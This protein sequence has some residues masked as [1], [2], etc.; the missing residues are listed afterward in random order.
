MLDTTTVSEKTGKWTAALTPGAV[1]LFDFPSDTA[2]GETKKRPC[3]VIETGRAGDDRFVEIA[4]GT[5]SKSAA[6]AGLEIHVRTA[7]GMRSA[8][9]ERATRFVLRRRVIVTT[10]SPRIAHSSTHRSPVIGRLDAAAMARLAALR[11]RLW[12]E[13]MLAAT[14]RYERR[15]V[16]EGGVPVVW[17]STRR[18]LIPAPSFSR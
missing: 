17:R 11:G 10:D 18:P 1:I 14:R 2:D 15:S 16:T 3:L 9:L 12:E 8:G 5:S 6:N 4:Y 13:K 7:A